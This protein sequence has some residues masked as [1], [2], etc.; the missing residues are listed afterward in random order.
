MATDVD[1]SQM[2]GEIS[3]TIMTAR[4]IDQA[5]IQTAIMAG[6]IDKSRNTRGEVSYSVLT[7]TPTEK[8]NSARILIFVWVSVSA[9]SGFSPSHKISG[10]EEAKCLDKMNERMPPRKDS[11]NNTNNKEHQKS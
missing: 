7:K 4:S 2:R 5:Q 8:A 10:F 9:L 6:R 3:C 11:V 1:E